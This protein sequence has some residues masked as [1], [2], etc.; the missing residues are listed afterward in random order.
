MLPKPKLVRSSKSQSSFRNKVQRLMSHVEI[1]T[2]VPNQEFS[3]PLPIKPKT[4]KVLKMEIHEY[5]DQEPQTEEIRKKPSH[6]KSNTTKNAMSNHDLDIEFVGTTFSD[7]LSLESEVSSMNF[8]SQSCF[9]FSNFSPGL[10]SPGLES[11][12]DIG[13][14]IDSKVEVENDLPHEK[15]EKK[16]EKNE[17]NIEKPKKESIISLIYSP[18]LVQK[19]PIKEKAAVLIQKHW[20]RFLMRRNYLHCLRKFKICILM[21]D[22][23]EGRKNEEKNKEKIG[24][25][26]EKLKKIN[27]AKEKLLGIIRTGKKLRKK[28]KK[29][30]STQKKSKEAKKVSSG[31]Y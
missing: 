23:I 1:I 24:K 22:L 8:E 20:K 31:I 9:S 29:S 12:N 19:D 3:S 13:S 6:F 16:E 11:N 25:L 17:K 7:L 30:H 21:L 2:E 27:K 15:N 5:K 28:H 4:H 18:E 10:G 26:E 14:K